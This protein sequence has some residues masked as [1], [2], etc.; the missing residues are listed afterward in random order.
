MKN[1]NS[2]MNNYLTNKLMNHLTI[3]AIDHR[4]FTIA[5][6]RIQLEPF[7]NLQVFQYQ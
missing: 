1:K 6:S 7:Y 2:T 4:I 3:L 5:H